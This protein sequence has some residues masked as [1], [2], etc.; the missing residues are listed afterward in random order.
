MREVARRRDTR[1]TGADIVEP[2]IADN[3]APVRTPRRIAASSAST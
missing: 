2:L 1:Y 3:V